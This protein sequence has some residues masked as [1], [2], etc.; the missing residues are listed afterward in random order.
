MTRNRWFLLALGLAA[1]DLSAQTMPIDAE[2]GYRWTDIIGNEAMYRTQVNEEEGLLLRALTIASQDF[3]LDVSDLGAGP[4]SS[5]RLE[6]RRD[7]LYR[8][9]F[10]YR[11]ADAFSAIPGFALGQHTFDRTR[12]ILDADLEILHW[13]AIK[14]FVGYSWN[15]YEGPGTTTWHVGQD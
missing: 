4:A 10:R 6:T 5:I 11:R 3:R 15:R 1:I 14:P 8:F 13:A 2:I 9:N 7:G 12:D